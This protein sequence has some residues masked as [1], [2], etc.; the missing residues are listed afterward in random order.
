MFLDKHSRM[1][2]DAKDYL[3]VFVKQI[4]HLSK[5]RGYCSLSVISIKDEV[6]RNNNFT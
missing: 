2:L 1:S 6:Q 4:S 5:G 3:K